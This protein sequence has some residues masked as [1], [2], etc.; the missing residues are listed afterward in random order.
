MHTAPGSVEGSVLG[1]HRVGTAES[2]WVRD[3]CGGKWTVTV[4]G[5]MLGS[6]WVP[7]R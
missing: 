6:D 3:D 1:L 2:L 5:E 4:L 7:Y